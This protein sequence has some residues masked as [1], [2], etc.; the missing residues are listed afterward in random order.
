MTSIRKKL[1]HAVLVNCA[2]MRCAKAQKKLD[3]LIELEAPMADIREAE[4][5]VEAANAAL[6]QVVMFERVPA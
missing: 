6:Q 1:S 2:R 4:A 5:W 3:Q